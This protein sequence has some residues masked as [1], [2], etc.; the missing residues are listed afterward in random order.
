MLTTEND[1][2]AVARMTEKGRDAARVAVEMA[3]L[4]SR[5]N[6]SAATTKKTKKRNAHE[7]RPT[8]LARIR[9]P[10]ALPVAAVGCARREIDAQLRDAQGFDKADHEHLDAILNGVIARLA[11]RCP[12]PSRRAS[13]ARSSSCRRSSAAVL[14]VAAFELKHHIDIP[15]RVVINEAVELAKTFG[16]SDG[17]KYVNGVLDK[18]AVATAPGR[19]ARPR[20]RL[21]SALPA[22]PA[23][24]NWNCNDAHPCRTA[25]S[26]GGSASTP[27][28]LST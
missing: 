26:V 12:P 11:T 13:T 10:G 24:Q 16:G 9:D 7:E 3:N 25:R 21:S 17:H 27:S 6:S 4:P 5:W 2:Q 19:S 20:P 18:L 14:L 23:R 22:D 1:E 28:S 8:P 15:Y